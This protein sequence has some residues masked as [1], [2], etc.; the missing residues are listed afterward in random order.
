MKGT[1]FCCYYKTCL[2]QLLLVHSG[3]ESNPEVALRG[4]QHPPLGWESAWLI[5]CYVSS[6][7]NVRCF[8]F[9]RLVLFGFGIPPSPTGWTG[10]DHYTSWG[11]PCINNQKPQELSLEVERKEHSNLFSA[12]LSLL[13]PAA[14]GHTE[15]KWLASW[16]M[17]FSPILLLILRRP[18]CWAGN[19]ALSPPHHFLIRCLPGFPRVGCLLKASLASKITCAE[20]NLTEDLSFFS[21]S[22]VFPISE[23]YL[24]SGLYSSPYYRQ[25]L[26]FA[27]LF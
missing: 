12:P 22:I 4:V 24:I 21:E 9:S 6:L 19:T 5:S 23:G 10:G 27:I 20:T 3:P 14:E 13:L 8:M 26:T 18:S 15:D 11:L 2:S 1:S 17:P 7:S 25:A 16:V